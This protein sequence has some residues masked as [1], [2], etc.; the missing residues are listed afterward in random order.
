MLPTQNKTMREFSFSSVH[1]CA[2]SNAAQVSASKICF[3]NCPLTHP[4]DG[5]RIAPN[6]LKSTRWFSYF[7]FYGFRDTVAVGGA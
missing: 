5:H 6:M 1:T 2:A 3:E 4:L 7:Y